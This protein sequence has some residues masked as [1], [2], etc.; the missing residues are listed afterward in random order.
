MPITPPVG[1]VPIEDF[2][3]RRIDW[4]VVHH[5]AG[6]DTTLEN[7]SQI[8][9]SH[10][11]DNDYFD[12]GYH[13]VVEL[14]GGAF[15]AHFG[16]PDHVPGA[17]VRGF[18]ENSLGICIVGNYSRGAPPPGLLQVAARRV[19][20]PWAVQYSVPIDHIIGHRDAPN[21][22]T[23]CPGTFFDMDNFRELVSHY[24]P[25]SEAEHDPDAG[26]TGNLSATPL[27]K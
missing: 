17:H 8:W 16:R 7:F 5:S 27:G 10:V 21:A 25:Q 24:I 13:A 19:V 2:V 1:I 11:R 12:I 14:V 3:L 9:T 22:H 6:R 20:A 15:L 23:E 18:N 26:T 4:I